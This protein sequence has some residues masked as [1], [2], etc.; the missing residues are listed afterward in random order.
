VRLLAALI[1]ATTVASLHLSPVRV[2]VIGE[3][4]GAATG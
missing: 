2:T 1:A 4:A 3:A